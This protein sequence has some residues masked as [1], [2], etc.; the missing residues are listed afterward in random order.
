MWGAE[1]ERLEADVQDS[2]RELRRLQEDLGLFRRDYRSELDEA[3]R[4]LNAIKD[5][6]Q[7]CRDELREAHESLDEARRGIQSWH[8][9]SKRT[10]W[11]FGNA[12]RSLPKHSIFGQSFGDLDDLKAER[13]SAVDSIQTASDRRADLNRDFQVALESIRALKADRQRMFDLRKSGRNASFL[14]RRI[15]EVRGA[16]ETSRR[17]AAE[18]RLKQGAWE[19]SERTSRGI[20]ALEARREEIQ[21]AHGKYLAQFDSVEALAR[22][23][24]EHRAEW[25]RQRA[26]DSPE[27]QPPAD[28]Q[29]NPVVRQLSDRSRRDVKETRH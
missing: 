12:G 18:L 6:Q 28:Q 22:R 24:A 19:A 29:R 20:E 4:R 15:A 26:I 14:A 2:A 27:A 21:A 10:P 3:Y 8:N 13:A 25:L 9:K 1:I 16:A 7:L 23:K 11:L 17:R 5:E